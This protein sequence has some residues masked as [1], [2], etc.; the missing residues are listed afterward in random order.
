VTTVPPAAARHQARHLLSFYES[1][2]GLVE[3]VCTFVVAA[4]RACHLAVV[5]AGEAHRCA[6]E[7]AFRA[8]GHD[9]EAALD[10]GALIVLDAEET[11]GGFMDAGGPDPRR[12]DSVIGSIVRSAIAGGRP[13]SLFGGMVGCLWE[14]GNVAAAIEL[15]VLWNTLTEGKP[16]S[17]LCS[18]PA[19]L[20]DPR[21]DGS[22]VRRIRRLHSEVVGPVPDDLASFAAPRRPSGTS[23][24]LAT[25]ERTFQALEHAP[26]SARHFVMEV[27]GDWG[28]V[29]AVH[30]AALVVTELATNAVVHARSSFTL[31]VMI[32]DESIRISVQDSDPR[33]ATPTGPSRAE[34]SGRG[35]DIVAGIASRWGAEFLDG[36]KVVWAEI[37]R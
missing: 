30:N 8:A 21:A 11:L 32:G 22:W 31:R 29:E 5:V 10:D 17:L 26:R 15:E 23:D 13:V 3:Q 20:L 9:V 14:A 7:Q 19:M 6:F 4:I 25:F 35:L 33:P 37:G 1:E 18:Y 12:F 34:F 16:L 28:G 24:T 36:G 2:E 27:L